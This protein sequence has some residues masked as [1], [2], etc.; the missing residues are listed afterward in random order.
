M[1]AAGSCL[2]TRHPGEAEYVPGRGSIWPDAVQCA[3]VDSSL[4][5]CP[6]M[7]WRRSNRNRDKDSAWGVWR[8]QCQQDRTLKE[9]VCPQSIFQLQFCPVLWFRTV[10]ALTS[11]H[12]EITT[13]IT[14]VVNL[15]VSK[16]L[17]HH[18]SFLQSLLLSSLPFLFFPL[19]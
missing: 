15:Q 4:Y 11:W 2:T 16:V 3:S 5:G 9:C 10:H 14:V 18:F 7:P 12:L 8:G 19:T 6:A 13:L 17:W 1:L